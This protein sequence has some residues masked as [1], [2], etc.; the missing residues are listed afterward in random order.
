[1][2]W[3]PVRSNPDVTLTSLGGKAL[4]VASTYDTALEDKQ[5]QF[6]SANR[7]H[8]TSPRSN[9]GPESAGVRMLQWE[10]PVQHRIHGDTA[11]AQTASLN[12]LKRDHYRRGMSARELIYTDAD[13]VSKSMTLIATRITAHESG[14]DY[15]V[16]SAKWTVLSAY[17]LQPTADEQNDSEVGATSDV[18]LTLDNDGSDYSPAVR[19]ALTGTTA[20]ADGVGQRFGHYMTVVNRNPWPLRMPILITDDFQA[21]ASPGFPHN[22]EV[23]AFRS[24]S[25]GHDL[26]LYQNQRRLARWLDAPNTA[27]TRV[28]TPEISIPA[29]RWWTYQSTAT[30]SAVATSMTVREPLDRL[31][32]LPFY[33]AFVEGAATREVVLVTAGDATSGALTI[34]RGQRGTT[35]ATHAAGSRLYYCPPECLFDLIYGNRSL[36]APTYYIDDS[37][38]PILDLANSDNGTWR[39]DNFGESESASKVSLVKPRAASWGFRDTFDRSRE[40]KTGQGDMYLR[41]IPRTASLSTDAAT[42][43]SINIAHRRDG[44]LAFHPLISEFFVRFPYGCNSFTITTNTSTL[45]WNNTPTDEAKLQVIGVGLDGTEELL[46]EYFN[47]GATAHAHTPTA[48]IYEAILRLRVWDTKIDSATVEILPDEPANGDG[49][50]GD[51]GIAVFDSAEEV[52][53]LWAGARRNIYQWGRPDAPLEIANSEGTTLY[54]HGAYTDIDATLTVNMLTRE[55]TLPDGLSVTHLTSGE[56][57]EAPPDD[58][59]AGTGDWTV[60]DATWG[61]ATVTGYWRDAYA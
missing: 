2:S 11:A 56:W 17:R 10:V 30:L 55:A 58:G 24:D 18:T 28:W 14:A 6:G 59:V 54:V 33:A 32:P 52:L 27:A 36:P 12:R 13:G 37:F 40:K 38:K 47:E 23:S 34:A 1:M 15:A 16:V 21:G 8:L 53:V 26:E 19:I 45:G 22:T 46:G 49:A 39:W 29:G 44:A 57:P 48:N 5:L 61:T 9:D 43:S 42:W 31:P 4:A 60:V 25:N 7:E 35:A 51:T 20:K 41:Y 3:P 50:S